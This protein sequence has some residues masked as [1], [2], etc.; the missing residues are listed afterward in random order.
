MA[1]EEFDLELD[2]DWLYVEDDYSLAVSRS[3][4]HFN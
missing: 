2:L 1:D 3:G 4:V